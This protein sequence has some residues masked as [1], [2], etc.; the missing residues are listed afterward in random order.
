VLGDVEEIPVTLKHMC[1]CFPILL[2]KHIVSMWA[3]QWLPDH[4]NIGIL[5]ELGGKTNK[6]NAVIFPLHVN[7]VLKVLTL[8]NLKCKIAFIFKIFCIKE[9]K[10]QT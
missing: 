8:S 3:D 10:V 6:I 9:E 7:S 5:V 4:A 2:Y 1:I